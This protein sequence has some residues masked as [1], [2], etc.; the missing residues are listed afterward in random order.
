[1]TIDA[2]DTK[3]SWSFQWSGLVP[4]AVPL[5]FEPDH[6]AVIFTVLLNNNETVKLCFEKF[7]KAQQV[8]EGTYQ[9]LPS[10]YKANVFLKVEE[11]SA[12]LQGFFKGDLSRL[13][14]EI[15]ST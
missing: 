4:T 1:M 6:Q 5:K 10:G 15:F 7:N 3:K 12:R 13:N 11:A 9:I 8:I 2:I 14:F